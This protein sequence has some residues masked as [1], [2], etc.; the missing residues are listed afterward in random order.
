LNE[1]QSSFHFPQHFFNETG[2]DKLLKSTGQSGFSFPN[3]LGPQKR[4]QEN[5]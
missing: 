4:K 3:G 1:V 2:F 5:H